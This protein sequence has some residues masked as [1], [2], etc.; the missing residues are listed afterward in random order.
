MKWYSSTVKRIG[1]GIVLFLFPMIV[2]FFIFEKAISIVQKIILPIKS[3]LPTERI[4]GVGVTSILSL[5]FILLVCFLAGW[6][7]ETKLVKSFLSFIEDNVLVFIPGYTLI[8]SEASESI[9]DTGNDWKVVYL[10]DEDGQTFGI[11]V[12]RH[13]DGQS[14][15][16]FPQPPDAK[17]GDMILMPESKFRRVD[18]PVNK[19]M[20][21]IRNYGL[22][23]EE[24]P[25]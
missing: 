22:G 19:L 9:K 4:F 24:L 15:I 8:K 6:L 11:E 14:M 23:S 10:N 17:S 7:Y 3:H 2:L 12:S 1:K 20:K 16:F 13:T 21:I 25:E 5:V 18:F